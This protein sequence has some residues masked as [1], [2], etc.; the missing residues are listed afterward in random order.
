M[1][2][3]DSIQSFTFNDAEH[4]LLA[5][6]CMLLPAMELLAKQGHLLPM[7]DP[8]FAAIAREIGSQ[9]ELFTQAMRQC[10]SD[11]YPYPARVRLL[12]ASSDLRK[13]IDRFTQNLLTSSPFPNPPEI[14]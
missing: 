14:L 1:S 6:R 9:R 7:R 5:L 11:E 12:C 3:T 2:V 8:E 4:E 13:R 10:H